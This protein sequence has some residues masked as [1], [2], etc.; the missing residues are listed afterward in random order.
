MNATIA[1]LFV[2]G[3]I[4]WSCAPAQ[5]PW[6]PAAGAPDHFLV[7]AHEGDATREPV[8]DGLCRS[9]MVDPSDGTKLVMDR[10]E[11]G[12]ADYIVPEGKYGVG[13]DE[14]LRIEC[15][16]GRPVGIFRREEE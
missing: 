7:G 14:V 4:S 11:G 6:R 9:P 13:K 15:A 10:A 12:F 3:W 8:A 5:A 16:T 2:A 1:L